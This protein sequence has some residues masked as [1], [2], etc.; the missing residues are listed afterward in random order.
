MVTETLGFW[1]FSYI[2]HMM[3]YSKY[4]RQ[5]VGEYGIIGT[6]RTVADRFVA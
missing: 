6:I 4:G 5:I 1:Y 2:N 3:R